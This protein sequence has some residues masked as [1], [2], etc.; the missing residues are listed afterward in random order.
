MTKGLYVVRLKFRAIISGMQARED[1]I[2][3]HQV[4]SGG[5]P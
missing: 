5:L 3:I 1:L 2:E 4:T